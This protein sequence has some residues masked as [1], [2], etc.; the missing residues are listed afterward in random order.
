MTLNSSKPIK[1]ALGLICVGA[2]AGLVSACASQGPTDNPLAR[3]ISWFSYLEGGDIRAACGPNA[4]NSYRL[5]YN[6]VFTEQVRTYDLG[7]DRRLNVGV[8]GAAE[9]SQFDVSTL[10]GLLNPWRA[11]AAIRNLS[12]AETARITAALERDGAFG[13]PAVDTELSSKG[14]FWT[15]AACHEGAYHF[16]ALAWP[17][18]AWDNMTFDDVVFDLDPSPIAVNPPRK[19]DTARDAKR[20][21]YGHVIENEFHTKVGENGLFGV[22]NLGQ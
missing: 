7:A 20:G 19:T 15:I 18:P 1:I 21:R 14:F 2:L 5:V 6:G 9:V 12:D 16:T 3:K 17:S 13:A 8:I 10:S 11:K 22:I 4:S